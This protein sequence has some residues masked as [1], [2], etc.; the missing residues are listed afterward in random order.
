MAW[1]DGKDGGRGGSGGGGEPSASAAAMSPLDS[2]L[3]GPIFDR[4]VKELDPRT[5]VNLSLTS[6]SLQRQV[7]ESDGWRQLC[8]RFTDSTPSEWNRGSYKE[9]Y[10]DVCQRYGLLLRHAT[11]R[12]ATTPYGGLLYVEAQPPRIVAYSVIAARTTSAQLE[13]V[14]VFELDF[15]AGEETSRCFRGEWLR[16]K[17]LHLLNEERNR[18]AEGQ[19][20]GARRDLLPSASSD[21]VHA[22]T[23]TTHRKCDSGED[24]GEEFELCCSGNCEQDSSE[25]QNRRFCVMDMQRRGL[26]EEAER[27]H[28][29]Q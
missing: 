1:E 5:L 19:T 10:R 15:T 28:F 12:A 2:A 23:L 27:L 11:W 29:F 7:Q 17:T 18:E 4:V 13:R 16:E 24:E 20:E 25:R 26:E 21:D 14:P 9:L 8:R 22:C 6:K 3:T